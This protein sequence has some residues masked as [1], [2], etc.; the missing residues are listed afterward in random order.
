MLIANLLYEVREVS[1]FRLALDAV[2]FVDHDHT[3]FA[4]GIVDL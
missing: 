2:K 3:I 1:A 4:P